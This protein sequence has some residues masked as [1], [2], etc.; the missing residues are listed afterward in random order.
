MLPTTTSPTNPNKRHRAN[1]TYYASRLIF[2]K[3]WRSRVKLAETIIVGN[4]GVINTWLFWSKTARCLLRKSYDTLNDGQG[5]DLILSK[6]IQPPE[7]NSAIHVLAPGGRAIFC[8]HGL[9]KCVDNLKKQHGILTDALD[10]GGATIKRTPDSVQEQDRTLDVGEFIG[11]RYTA[12]SDH[13]VFV[14]SVVRNPKAPS[15]MVEARRM[16]FLQSTFD[17]RVVDHS[18]AYETVDPSEA[19][20]AWTTLTKPPSTNEVRPTYISK[21]PRD[22]S[23]KSD[24]E[25]VRVT[26]Y[27]F[28]I[29]DEDC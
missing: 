5:H 22:D 4:D 13:V 8:G 27:F 29:I 11:S 10:E 15:N 16:G 12:P 7:S 20:S 9:I 19:M 18:S 17:I 14:V 2:C 26:M 25:Q 3:L 1:G 21:A 23:S 6:F 28:R 24:Y